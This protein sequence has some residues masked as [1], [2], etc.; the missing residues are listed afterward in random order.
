[1]RPADNTSSVASTFHAY[2]LFLASLSISPQPLSTDGSRLQYLSIQSKRQRIYLR[3]CHHIS[4]CSI[5]NALL[6]FIHSSLPIERYP[7]VS[8]SLLEYTLRTKTLNS[9]RIRSLTKFNRFSYKHRKHEQIWN[10]CPKKAEPENQLVP[11]LMFRSHDPDKTRHTLKLFIYSIFSV[12]AAAAAVSSTV[13][14]QD[15]GNGVLHRMN[16]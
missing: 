5:C 13:E 7:S 8:I 10:S 11:V 1:M 4:F 12:F 9:L 16:I 15:A 3:L 2:R 6:L 14:M